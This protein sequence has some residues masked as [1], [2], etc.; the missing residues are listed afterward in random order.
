MFRNGG[1]IYGLFSNIPDVLDLF[2]L[3]RQENACWYHTYFTLLYFILCMP[4]ISDE[5]LALLL[6]VSV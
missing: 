2:R 6:V 5:P 4:P 3:L 1:H